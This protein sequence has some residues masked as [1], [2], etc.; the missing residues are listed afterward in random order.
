VQSL[1]LLDFMDNDIPDN[2]LYT[3]TQADINGNAAIE[4]FA[5]SPQENVFLW[6]RD[7]F[8]FLVQGSSRDEAFNL[9]SS[10]K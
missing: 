5:S 1:I 6:Q 4:V 7:N 8:V 2:S 3:K 10:I 9:A